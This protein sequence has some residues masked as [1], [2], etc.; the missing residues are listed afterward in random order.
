[1]G[2][3]SATGLSLNNMVALQQLLT[4][5]PITIPTASSKL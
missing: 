3:A 4:G 1:L 2:T 5:A